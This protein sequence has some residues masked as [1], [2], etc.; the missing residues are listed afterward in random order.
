MSKKDLE[1]YWVRLRGYTPDTTP[2]AWLAR[3][4]VLDQELHA[5]DSLAFRCIDGAREL[6]TREAKQGPLIGMVQRLLAAVHQQEPVSLG[7]YE[8]LAAARIIM[9]REVSEATETLLQRKGLS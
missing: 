3:R 1:D 6:L 2:D 9:E 8:V 5:K 4:R 7:L